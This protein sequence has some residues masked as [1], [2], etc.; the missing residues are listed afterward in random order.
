MRL[1]VAATVAIRATCAKGWLRVRGRV[2]GR[3]NAARGRT[4][5]TTQRNGA[6][7]LDGSRDDG[8]LAWQFGGGGDGAPSGYM[9]RR[10]GRRHV[11]GARVA[12]GFVARTANSPL[13]LPVRRGRGG[14]VMSE[15]AG[16]VRGPGR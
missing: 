2:A 16:R 1:S 7:L 6:G 15:D 11:G 10:G 13:L 3:P 9:S 14:A 12:H 4:G 5:A 8:L